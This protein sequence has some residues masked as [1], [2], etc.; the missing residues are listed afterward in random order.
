MT[1]HNQVCIDRIL[2]RDLYRP[3]IIT[4]D[5][6]LRAVAPKK[7]LWPNGTTLK[8][9]FLSGVHEKGDFVIRVANEW[10]E[11]ANLKFEFSENP[12]AHIRIGFNANDG[13]WS[14]VGTDCLEENYFPKNE[15]TMNFGWLDEGVVLHEFGHAI[16]LGHE[17]QNPEGGIQWNE[18][19]VIEALKGPPNFWSEQVTRHNVINKYS[20]NHVVGTDFDQ[21][22]IMLYFF[23]A[24]WTLNNFS[25]HENEQLSK[26]DKV[27]IASEKAYPRT[28]KTQDDV[29]VDL[30]VNAKKLRTAKIGLPGEED[31]FRF[32]VKDYGYHTIYTRGN[33]DLVMRLY[34]PD[35]RTKLVD[36]D[37]DSG[38][39]F[40]A[41][42]TGKLEPGEY[43]V[44]IRH[45]NVK[46]GLGE[47]EIGV[48]SY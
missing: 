23:P 10:L 11:Y 4:G 37:D 39:D 33:T 45:A 48:D 1:E 21:D 3:L 40:N 17:H 30:D 18:P 15:R 42:I 8:V 22:S 43:L 20:F 26:Q 5:R 24:E 28:G 25:T 46:A 14:A 34:G 29:I 44:Q 27:F 35:D 38:Q 41:R 6:V 7:S 32:I 2:Q 13:S 9:C 47:Y 19:V 31:L 36:E 12:D 16:G